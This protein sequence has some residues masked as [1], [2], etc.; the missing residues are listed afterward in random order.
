MTVR[1]FVVVDPA[2]NFGRPALSRT[3]VAVGDVVAVLLAGEDPDSLCADFGLTRGDLLVACWFAARYG[4]EGRP[5]GEWA[6]WLEE[7]E[8]VI[9]RASCD[10]EAVPLPVGED[11]GHAQH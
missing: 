8:P 4:V 7:W 1:P 5:R 3:R 10:Y 11:G 2:Q 9:W 6:A